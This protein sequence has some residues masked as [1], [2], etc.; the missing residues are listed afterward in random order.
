MNTPGPA[1]SGPSSQAYS[2]PDQIDLSGPS[3]WA[4]GAL[5]GL[6]EQ[7]AQG[8][9]VLCEGLARD[10][11]L[12][13][14]LTRTEVLRQLSTLTVS[15]TQLDVAVQAAMPELDWAGWA[16]L[17]PRLRAPTGPELD[18]ALWFAVESLVPATLLWL[19]FY[20]Q[21]QPRWF[22]IGL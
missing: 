21:Q 4:T 9:L 5:L 2:S 3:P 18:E 22:R 10:E 14:R 1:Q 8:V 13:S 15:A 17:A 7:A 20:R 11:L 19:R 12:G 6:I 16:A